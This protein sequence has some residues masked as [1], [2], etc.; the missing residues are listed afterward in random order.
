M[1][2]NTPCAIRTK[3]K[4]GDAL[5]TLMN[6]NSFDRITV[7]DITHECNIHRQ[8]FYYHF[9]DRYELLDWTIYY[10]LVEPFIT[11]FSFDNM[12][13]KFYKMFQTMY[14]DKKFYQSAF[15]VNTS[16]LSN[17]VGRAA[18][19]QLS[20][21]FNYIGKTNDIEPHSAE[22]QVLFAEFFGF[23]LSG[24]VMSWAQKGMKETPEAMTKRIEHLAQI[25]I[26][27]GVQRKK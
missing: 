8:T 6:N 27:I 21:L 9:Q 22:E 2:K 15:K 19:E 4:M 10:E 13:D 25:C 20:D 24:V 3:K 17:Y 12:Y 7:S 1:D 18:K 11:D 23:G 5:K 16:D 26:R 14:E